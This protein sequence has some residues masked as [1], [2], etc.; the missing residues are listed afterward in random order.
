MYTVE[1]RVG[2]L[3]EM[4]MESPLEL[5]DVQR[6]KAVVSQRVLEATR[7]LLCCTDLRHARIFSPD[8]AAELTGMM[9]LDNPRVKRNA[10]L[11]G[12][13]ALFSM[14]IE[15][16]VREAGSQSRRTFRDQSEAQLWLREHLDAEE[17][18]RLAE[19][20]LD[21]RIDRYHTI[22]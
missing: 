2:R 9:K 5:E 15:R 20:M 14:Q 17:R 11:V 10:I 7:P 4:R 3:L 8:A 12:E 21:R 1:I 22:Q 13:S 6:F 19:F 18:W 16:M